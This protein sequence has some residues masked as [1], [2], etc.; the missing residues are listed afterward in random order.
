MS[1]FKNDK[2]PCPICGGATPRIFSTKI[3]GQPL[4]GDCASHLSVQYDIEQKMTLDDVREHFAF[5]DRNDA[6]KACFC[7]TGRVEFSCGDGEAIFDEPNHR[8]YFMQSKNK[9][10]FHGSEVLTVEIREDSNLIFRADRN[11][12]TWRDTGLREQVNAMSA[13]INM[14]NMID[15]MQRAQDKEHATDTSFSDPMRDWH[16][17]ITLEHP[18]WTKLETELDGPFWDNSE[19]DCVKFIRDYDTSIKKLKEFAMGMLRTCFPEVLARTEQAN[20]AAK[21]AAAAPAAP[22]TGAAEEIKKFKELLDV[23]AITQEEFDAK[24]KQLLGL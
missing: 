6:E 5:R 8:F 23:G 20:N 22:A 21:A 16:I 2:K 9:I 19:P 14:S 12:Y 18:Y 10:L 4:C 11:S 1:L 15:R 24:K 17:V 7:E 13:Q 3:E